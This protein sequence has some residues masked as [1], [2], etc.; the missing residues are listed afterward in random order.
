MKKKKGKKKQ[1]ILHESEDKFIGFTPTSNTN[2]LI[3]FL[4]GAIKILLPVSFAKYPT[5]RIIKTFSGNLIKTMA[6][7]L[8]QQFLLVLSLS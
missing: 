1:S 3:T 5:K 7:F 2:S 8:R 4:K 6:Y